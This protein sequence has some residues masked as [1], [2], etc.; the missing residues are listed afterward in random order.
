[1]GSTIITFTF[2]NLSFNGAENPFG[3]HDYENSVTNSDFVNIFLFLNIEQDINKYVYW[4][5]DSTYKD[6]IL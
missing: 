2:L 5:L 4:R 3:L 6:G 1:M